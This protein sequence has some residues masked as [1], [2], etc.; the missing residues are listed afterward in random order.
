MREGWIRVTIND[1]AEVKS[2][3]RLPKGETL[4]N[5]KTAHP[6]IRGRD[7]KN[8]KITFDDPKYI[9]DEVYEQIKRYTAKYGDICL[10]IVANIGDVGQVPKFLDG[11]NLTENA[12]KLVNIREDCYPEY[13]K[14]SL[15][16]PVNKKQMELSAAGAAQSKLGIY[17][18]KAIKVD[19]PNSLDTQRKIASIL[20]SYDDFIENN[21]RRIKIREEMAQQIYCE[22]FVNFHFPGHE[23]VKMMDSGTEFGMIPEGWQ[24]KKLSELVNTQYGYTESAREEAVGPKYVRGT[25]IN[26]TSYV[27]WETV[28]YCPINKQNWD[29]YKLSVGDILVIRMADPGKVGIIEKNIDAV[30]ASYLIRLIPRTDHLSPYYLFYFLS[31]DY[32]QD[33]ITGASTGTTRKS[34]S[35]G[36]ITDVLVAI[37]PSEVR[38][39]FKIQIEEIRNLMN[40][41]IDQNSVLRQTRDLLLP[42]FIS[43]KIDVE[44]LDIDVE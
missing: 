36:V 31:S 10:T 29:K 43:G 9:T 28:P 15:S 26:K 19:L 2:G 27:V 8:G 13:L 42:K 16:A 39:A 41:L 22:W 4:S 24:V 44:D 23:N 5:E 7:I 25:D 34:A 21:T 3:K 18:V 11:A 33:Y 17:K 20:S 12:V 1:I 32:Y 40:N 37:P 38:E 35:A 30:F 6:Y 14:Y